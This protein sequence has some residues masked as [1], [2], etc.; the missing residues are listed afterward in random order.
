MKVFKK[1]KWTWAWV[2]WPFWKEWS[3]ALS[4]HVPS[5]TLTLVCSPANGFARHVIQVSR[6]LSGQALVSKGTGLLMRESSKW[7]LKVSSFWPRWKRF[8]CQPD[9][10]SAG[11]QSQVWVSFWCYHFCLLLLKNNMWIT[12]GSHLFLKSGKDRKLPPSLWHGF[13]SSLGEISEPT[14]SPSSISFL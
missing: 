12:W 9:G 3:P 1:W 5:H 4:A 6:D 8:A 11:L 7:C 14:L 13:S 10:L 2:H